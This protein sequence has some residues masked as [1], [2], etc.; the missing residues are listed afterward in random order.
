MART[1]DALPRTRGQ[2]SREEGSRVPSEFFLPSSPR[3]FP[4]WSALA[5]R[6]VVRRIKSGPRESSL[7]PP[8]YA[9][10][11]G[12]ARLHF[13][14]VGDP[15]PRVKPPSTRWRVYTVDKSSNRGNLRLTGSLCNTN[16]SGTKRKF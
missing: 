8:D 15:V 13:A 9:T 4:L 16:G 5:G 1:P 10:Y 14:A 12:T 6:H 7:Y 2:R 11:Q 3:Y